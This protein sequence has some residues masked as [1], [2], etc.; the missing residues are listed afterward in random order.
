MLSWQ[1]IQVPCSSDDVAILFH[2]HPHMICPVDRLIPAQSPSGAQGSHQP[3]APALPQ[4]EIIVVVKAFLCFHIFQ[5]TGLGVKEVI[6][7]QGSTNIEPLFVSVFS[8]LYAWRIWVLAVSWGQNITKLTLKF[9]KCQHIWK[10]QRFWPQ[11]SQ[12][13]FLHLMLHQSGEPFHHGWGSR[14][15][16]AHTSPSSLM[17]SCG[18]RRCCQRGLGHFRWVSSGLPGV[19]GDP[20]LIPR[21]GLSAV[22]GCQLQPL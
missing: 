4:L 13:P 11:T 15:R 2:A 8:L 9:H 19:S 1:S 3:L 6:N 20:S 22:R 7:G 17:H 12:Q 21:F 5:I 10:H 16:G 14:A 18:Y